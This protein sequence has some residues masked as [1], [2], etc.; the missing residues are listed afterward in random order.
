[1]ASNAAVPAPQYEKDPALAASGKRS[2]EWAFQSMPVLQSI[3]KQLIKSQSLAGMRIAA[4]L[5]AT[6]ETANLMITL[7]D[8][9]ASPVLCPVSQE[10]LQKEVAVSLEQEYGI[11]VIP[12][13]AAINND[14]QILLDS[15]AALAEEW[16]NRPGPGI[17]GSTESNSGGIIRLK[18]MAKS[19][20]LHYPVIA[21]NDAMTKHLFDNR[22]GTGQSTMDGTR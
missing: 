3:R 9:G 4:C 15:G 5:H 22:Y 11:P 14:P 20:I 17:L 1:M 6:T 7:R 8:A 12:A 21:V 18:A 10:S 13:A 19:G 2:I 16:K